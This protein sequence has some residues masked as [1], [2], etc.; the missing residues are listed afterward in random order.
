MVRTGEGRVRLSA[1][2]VLVLPA[3]H[4]SWCNAQWGSSAY[5]TYLGG[6]HTLRR[7]CFQRIG[8]RCSSGSGRVGRVER[9]GHS[10]T[11]RDGEGS[12]LQHKTYIMTFCHLYVRLTSRWS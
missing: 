5:G 3:H 6:R 8:A 12:R 1:G 10:K 11:Q 4:G 9:H 7:P 2:G